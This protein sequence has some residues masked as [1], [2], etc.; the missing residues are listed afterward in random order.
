MRKIILL[1]I[2]YCLLIFGCS[3]SEDHNH[4]VKIG[5]TIK[6]LN[7]CFEIYEI[8]LDGNPYYAAVQGTRGLALTPKICRNEISCQCSAIDESKNQKEHNDIDVIWQPDETCS[9]NMKCRK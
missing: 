5:K 2:C 6:V 8:C 4:S 3:K 9:T 1:L 7:S